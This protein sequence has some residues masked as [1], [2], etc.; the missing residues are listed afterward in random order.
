MNIQLFPE[1]IEPASFK[2]TFLARIALLLSAPLNWMSPR[3]I[4]NILLRLMKS[5]PIASE[6]E[7]KNARNA[8]CLV[9]S[10]CRS[11]EGC[12]RRSLA[13]VLMIWLQ[14][15]SVSWCTGYAQEPFRAHAWVEINGHPVGEPEEVHIY[16]KAICVPHY[17]KNILGEESHLEK[18]NHETSKNKKKDSEKLVQEIQ[19]PSVNIRS[20]FALAKG[21]NWEFIFVGILGIISAILTLVQPNLVA[22]LINQSDKGIKITSSLGLLIIVLI[23]STVLTAIQYYLL[24]IIGEGVVFEARKSLI[25]HLLRLPICEYDTKSVGDLLSRVSGD[26]SKLRMALIQVTIALS[27][28]FLIVIGAAVGMFLKDS[29]LF[30]M[31]LSSVCLSFIGTIIMSKAIQK[32]SFLAQK[33]LGKLSGSIERD[34]HAIRTIRA[35]NATNEEEIKSKLQAER[36]RNI[37]I[38]LAKIQAFMTPVSNMTLQLSGLIVLG[39]GG[40][41]VSIGLM[42]IADLIAFALLLYTMIGPIGQIFNAFGGIGESLGAFARIRELLDIALENDYDV[43]PA[44]PLTSNS[45]AQGTAVYFKKISFGYN[46]LKFGSELVEKEENLILKEITLRAEKGKRTAIVGPSGAGKSTILQL[47]ERFYDPD[48]GQIF[49]HEKDYRN[50]SREELRKLI[51]YVEQDSPV[52]S[53]TLRDNLQLGNHK[54]NDS[55]CI[56]VLEEVNLQHLLSRDSKGLDMQ[57]GESGASLS[58]GERQRLAMARSLLSSAEIVLLDE[59]TSNLDSLNEMGMKKAV[60]KLKG[61]K[62]VIVVAHRLSTVIDSDIIYVL[63]HGRVVGSGSH[64]ELIDTVPLYRELAKEQ[65]VDREM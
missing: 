28:G 36:L 50:Y 2:E 39:V 48:D 5:Y 44:T 65:F 12:L 49:V 43:I 23:L 14:R 57:V 7:V 24:Q 40:Y 53:G 3:R 46:K 19:A 54:V 56:K 17:S 58:G 34:L 51:T 29:L 15:R 47:I 38:R 45:I 20:L 30:L 60:D 64:N 32:A 6:I 61:E 52:I 26:S 11:Q 55:D 13:V 25:S 63:E 37:G 35:T 10:R 31:A 22:D 16:S 1:E 33:E 4:E 9:S 41:R 59:L 8:V 42:S 62:T 27:S 18:L 21:H